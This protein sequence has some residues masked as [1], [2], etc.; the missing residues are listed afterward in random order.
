MMR[1][2]PPAQKLYAAAVV[3]FIRIVGDVGKM[4]G[5]PVGWAW[6]VRHRQEIPDNGS[7]LGRQVLG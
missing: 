6:R 4:V 1:G 5:Y 2:L 7:E 3:P